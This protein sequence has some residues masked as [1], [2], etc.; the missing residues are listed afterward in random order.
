MNRDILI[1]E[2][3]ILMDNIEETICAL[4]IAEANVLDKRQALDAKLI[5]YLSSAAP[6]EIEANEAQRKAR[7]AIMFAAEQK[8]IT[9]AKVELIH[10][11]LD[12]DGLKEKLK[13]Y[14]ML[15]ALTAGVVE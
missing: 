15:T 13:C 14:Q 5:A 1:N 3:R 7:L 11:K 12:F 10:S 6:E 2:I 9:E 8:N 4:Q